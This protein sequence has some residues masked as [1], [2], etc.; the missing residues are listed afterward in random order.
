MKQCH[1]MTIRG[2]MLHREQTAAS[3]VEA[4]AGEMAR[5]AIWACLQMLKNDSPPFAPSIFLPDLIWISL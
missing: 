5:A 4:H 1:L 3:P 2:E